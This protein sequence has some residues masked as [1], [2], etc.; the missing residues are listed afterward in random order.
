MS[1]KLSGFFAL[2][3]V[4]LIL[5]LL[6]ALIRSAVL[7]YSELDE[8][9]GFTI[10]PVLFASLLSSITGFIGGAIRK[11]AFGSAFFW[12]YV[13]V[14]ALFTLGNIALLFFYAQY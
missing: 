4:A 5:A 10:A 8:V 1:Q 13:V 6:V 14:T 7:G 3:I 2:T 9:I 12:S 11:G